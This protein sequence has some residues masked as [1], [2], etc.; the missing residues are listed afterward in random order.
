M[1]GIKVDIQR[2]KKSGKRKGRSTQPIVFLLFTVNSGNFQVF[3]VVGRKGVVFSGDFHNF[4]I[5]N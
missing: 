2:Y 3:S 5:H 1:A 4:E